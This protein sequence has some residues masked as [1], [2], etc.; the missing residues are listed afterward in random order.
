MRKFFFKLFFLSVASISAMAQKSPTRVLIIGLDGFSTE[1]YKV[2]KHP[3]IDKMVADGVLSLSTRPVMP[4]ITLPNWTSHMTSSGPEEHG[5][6][7]NNWTLEKHPL[8]AIAV[9]EQGYYPSIFKVLKDK[10]PNV[11]TAYYYN[12]KELINPINQ[13]Y[14]DEVAFEENDGYQTNYN[15]AFDFIRNNKKDPSLIFLYSVHTDHA[16]HE[17]GWMSA[18]YIKAIE[19][20]DVAIGALLEKLKAEGLYKDTHFLLITDHGGI[21]KGHGGVTMNEMQIPWAIT[22]PQIKKRGLVT[23]FNSNKN[24]SFV[25]ARLFGISKLPDAWT[26]S[27]PNVIF[28]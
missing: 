20:A 11:K 16:G 21:N 23:D 27:L 28:K 9:D 22:G 19:E 1:G 14:L 17:F 25:L 10:I 26:G 12:W 5:V 13:K 3:N 6:T 24:T 7:A 15:K 8:P 2:A 18:P 4:S